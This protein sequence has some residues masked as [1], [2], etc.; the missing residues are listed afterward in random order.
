M[1]KVPAAACGVDA[2]F[3]SSHPPSPQVTAPRCAKEHFC[4]SS[5]CAAQAMKRKAERGAAAAAHEL[6]TL[7][8]ADCRKLL[9]LLGEFGGAAAALGPVDLNEVSWGY[10]WGA[11]LLGVDCRGLLAL[12]CS[13]GVPTSP[14]AVALVPADVHKVGS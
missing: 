12:L 14:Q 4:G 2:G 6:R 3:I 1:A 13:T 10:M 9:A 11:M 5:H 7:P 8:A